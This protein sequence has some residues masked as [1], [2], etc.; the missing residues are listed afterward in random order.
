MWK[1]FFDRLKRPLKTM[2]NTLPSTYDA[3]KDWSW[4]QFAPY[5]ADLES[6]DLTDASAD[7]FLKDWS[8]LSEAIG[9][10]LNR[11]RIL[12][13]QNTSDEI[14]E[15]HLRTLMESLYQPSVQVGNA[16][17]EKLLASGVQPDNFELPLKRMRAEVQLFRE[18]NLPLQL[19]EQK[20][21]IEYSK[22]IGGQVVQWDGEEVTLTELVKAFQETDRA[23]RKA[24][25]DLYAGRWLQDRDA[26]NDIWKRAF[27]VRNQMAKN[28][29]FD[30][31]RDYRW[32]QFS[33]F[34]YTPTDN[35]TFHDAI[36]Q[37][38]VPAA[39]RSRERRR[40]TLNLDVLRPY[41]MDT[42]ST[43]LPPL[44][45][46]KDIDD[47]AA[48]AESVFNHVDPQLGAYY[49]TLRHEGLLD[50]PNRKHKGPG[51]Y[52]SSYPLTRRPF[53]FMNAV[54]TRSDI[55]TLLHEIGHAFHEFE[56]L[57]NLPYTQQR[58]YP[59]EFAEVASMAMELLAAPYL[60]HEFGGYYDAPDAARDRIE[61]LDQILQ[62]WPYMAMVDA[63]QLWAY[64]GTD[65]AAD[66]AACDAKWLELKARFEP[67]IDYGGYADYKA[68]GWHRKQHIF[69]YPMYYVEYGLA[70]LG[71]VQVWANALKDQAGAVKSYREALAL[72][73]TG[74][75][76]ELFGAAGAK[77]AFDAD[78]LGVAVSLIESTIAGLQAI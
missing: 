59:I 56:T 65:R 61:H 42:D 17:N 62:F 51:A 71:S 6:R 4:E 14:A 28:A 27:P 49:A 30:T 38:V 53:V 31:Y 9:E 11:A 46:W 19:E 64:D 60:T 58:D 74:T 70:R 18:E 50:L 35:Q 55:R 34:D 32:L 8:H 41:D 48:K 26:L 44:R 47:F 36:E 5:F 63:F 15:A 13:T 69:R 77:F 33:R 24:A 78:T 2:F 66:P 10:I 73:G 21:G 72:G 16:L 75:M 3:L 39:V 12:T 1:L 22:V 67:D 29:G 40:Q 45:P 57:E 37:V 68:T 43:G 7:S 76:H 20:L 25:F 23:R 54:N 52:C